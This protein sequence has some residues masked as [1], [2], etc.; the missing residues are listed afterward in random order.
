MQTE[1]GTRHF[2]GRDPR[3]YSGR[4]SSAI[5]EFDVVALVGRTRSGRVYKLC[6]P[7]GFDSNAEYVWNRWCHINRVQSS[8]DVTK[9]AL[10][11]QESPAQE[12]GNGA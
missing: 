12:V 10:A 11:V 1:A 4:V 2:V 6:G 8:E 7:S 3:D 9:A 5:Q